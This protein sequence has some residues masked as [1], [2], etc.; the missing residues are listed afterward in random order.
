MTALIYYVRTMIGRC[1]TG[2]QRDA[3]KL[4]H[5]VGSPAD[6]CWDRALCGARPGLRGNGWSTLDTRDVS[7]PR[8][9]RKIDAMRQKIAEAA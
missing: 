2:A 7:C 1:A 6:P 9:Q 8:C 4:R 5:A 3:G